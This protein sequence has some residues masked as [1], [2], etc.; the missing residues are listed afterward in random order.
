VSVT[1]YKAV[2]VKPLDWVEALGIWGAP[3][4]FG[5]SYTVS[6][7]QWTY[8]PTMVWFWVDGGNDAA[9]QAAQADYEARIL[10][11]LE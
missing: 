6:D 5:T 7:S 10:S 1:P 3:T 11:A 9:K 4:A 2:R 8:G